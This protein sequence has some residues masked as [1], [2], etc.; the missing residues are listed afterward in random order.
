MA[1]PLSQQFPPLV[2]ALDH[3]HF[4]VVLCAEEHLGLGY[5]CLSYM[6][7]LHTNDLNMLL[8]VV[9]PCIGCFLLVSVQQ[10]VHYSELDFGP[11]K[12]LC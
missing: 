9:Q 11:K 7:S 8:R 4:L 12:L 10:D 3:E 5:Y 1:R 2:L 6:I